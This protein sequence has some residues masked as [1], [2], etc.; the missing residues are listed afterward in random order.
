MAWFDE[1]PTMFG[2]EGD[3]WEQ[4]IAQQGGTGFGAGGGGTINYGELSG[5]LGTG[6]EAT[7]EDIIAY[8]RRLTGWSVEDINDG[9]IRRKMG[10]M[11]KIELD[12]VKEAAAKEKYQLTTEAIGQKRQDIQQTFSQDA[13]TL[14]QGLGAGRKKL[15]SQ[16]GMSGVRAPGQGGFQGTQELQSKG[17]QQA[18]KLRSDLRSNIY[19]LG[20]QE[21]E[22]KMGYEQDIY[23]LGED[24]SKTFAD[25]LQL[26]TQDIYG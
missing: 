14:A 22:S 6:S 12:K 19:G 4:Q 3:I 16:S 17:Y 10:S 25:W 26:Q 11:P 1:D 18:G 5:F 20:L 23:G 8:I 24:V 9:E 7:F 15:A 13:Q 21:Q 2:A